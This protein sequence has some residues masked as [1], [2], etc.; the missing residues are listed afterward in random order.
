VPCPESARSSWPSLL[1]LV[2]HQRLDRLRVPHSTESGSHLDIRGATFIAPKDDGYRY[3]WCWPPSSEHRCKLETF[4]LS[5]PAEIYPAEI[6]KNDRFGF[7]SYRPDLLLQ[8]GAVSQVETMC[9][10]ASTVHGRTQLY[11]C[12]GHNSSA[13]RN[14]VGEQVTS[15]VSFQAALAS[16]HFHRC[17]TAMFLTS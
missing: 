9:V 8:V 14:R 15:L 7:Q 5:K 10:R 13:G 2:A 6:L 3:C 4:E 17:C 12:T 11:M 1:V 16:M